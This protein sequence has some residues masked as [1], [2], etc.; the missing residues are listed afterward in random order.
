MY[1]TLEQILARFDRPETQELTRLTAPDG[2]ERDDVAIETALA[3]AS[4]QMDLYIGSRN[5]L[6]LSGLSAAQEAD[7]ARMACDIARYRLHGEQAT[8]Q[9]R[10]RYDDTIDALDGIAAGRINLSASANG[11][12]SGKASASAGARVMTRASLGGVL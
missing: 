5:T 11:A 7:L 1:A 2:G 10:T 9:V 3:E 8:E 12:A 6:P 4:G